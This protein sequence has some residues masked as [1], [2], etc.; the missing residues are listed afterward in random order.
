MTKTFYILLDGNIIRDVIEYPHE[1]Y[2][3]VQLPFP[4]PIGINGGWWKWQDGQLV[5]CPELKPVDPE[6]LETRLA[7]AE[8]AILALL[9]PP[10]QEVK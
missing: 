1:G 10:M 2:I 6:S 9:F 3:E 8:D 5:E 4:L 7:A